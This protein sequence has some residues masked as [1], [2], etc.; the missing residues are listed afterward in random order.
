MYNSGFLFNMLFQFNFYSSWLLIFFIH[1]FVYACLLFKKGLK[2][3]TRSDKWLALFLLLCILYITPWMVGFAG[4]Y[5]NQPYRDILFYFPTQQLFFIGPVVFFYTQSLLNPAFQFTRKQTWHLL[6]GVL[7]FLFTLVVV[8]TDKVIL[9]RYYFLANGVDP[10]L[11]MWYQVL[12][13]FSML[14]YFLMAFRYYTIYRKMIVQVVSYADLFLFKWMK[15]FLLAFLMMLL[16]QLFFFIIEALV[17]AVSTYVG[18]WW[19]FL[20]FSIIFYYI[21]ITG[22]A[23]TIEQKVAFRVQDLLRATPTLQLNYQDS[24]TA[25]PG[26]TLVYTDF[27]EILPTNDQQEFE[28]GF[29]VESWKEKLIHLFEVE[30]MHEN[31]ELTVTD[32]AKQLQ[33]PPSMISKIIN[34][35]FQV[36]FNDYVNN[37]RVAAVMEKLRNGEQKIQTLLGI[38]Y[39]CGFNSK[40]TFN[41][42]FKKI[43]RQSPKEWIENNLKD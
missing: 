26:E 36:N 9:K 8:I 37:Y 19:Y 1:G 24:K 6:P 21:A 27:V 10:D 35:G 3:E 2:N 7:Y 25:S 14:F 17:P 41:R 39:D 29:P 40:A 22:Y 38:A 23:S 16:M 42:S 31:P 33:L 30:K 20:S 32:I 4:W 15:N 12:G 11:D 5:D 18:N 13:F 28:N 43:T 34:K